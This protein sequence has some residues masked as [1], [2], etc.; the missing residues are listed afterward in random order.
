MNTLLLDITNKKLINTLKSIK[1]NNLTISTFSCPK[2]YPFPQI[3]I[4]DFSTTI[5][6]NDNEMILTEI[7]KHIVPQPYIVACMSNWNQEYIHLANIFGI[8]R[9]VTYD[10]E[11]DLLNLSD[12]LKNRF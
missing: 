3:V 12:M 2:L 9:I 8:N 5:Q 10:D 11:E 4:V 7:I 6:S 1:N